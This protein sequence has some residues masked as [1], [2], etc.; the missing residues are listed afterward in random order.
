[1]QIKGPLLDKRIIQR[2]RKDGS[3]DEKTYREMLEKLPDLRDKVQKNE[4]TEHEA[5]ENDAEPKS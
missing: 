4:A 5:S 1:M 3:L 2:A